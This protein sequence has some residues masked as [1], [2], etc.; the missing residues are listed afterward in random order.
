MK[1]YTIVFCFL[2]FGFVST[3]V[4]A[5]EYVPMLDNLNEWKFTTCN[6]GCIT[7]TYFTDGDTLVNGMNFKILDGYHYISRTFLLREVVAEKKV[8]L[9]IF[10][11][12]R[13]E[14]YLL[15]DFSLE[16][17]DTFE[18]FNPITPFPAEGGLFRLDSI[19]SRTSA[20]NNMYRHFYFSPTPGNTISTQNAVW[21]EGVGSLSILTAPG[22]DPDF[23]NVGHLSCSFKNGTRVYENLEE[24]AACSPS[25][26]NI[27]AVISPLEG[28]FIYVKEETVVV[29]NASEIEKVV[30]YSI[31]GKKVLEKQLNNNNG[32][33]VLQTGHIKKG[34]Y[35]LKATGRNGQVAT[36]KFVSG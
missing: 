23:D 18:M 9:K 34:L 17:G 7:D 26:L 3:Q 27:D 33:M 1:K 8:Y 6:S 10:L 24:I 21:I 32:H 28:V 35:I 16:E 25:I 4:Y 31:S 19:R 20:D 30:I 22:G 14:D 5:Q 11:P 12:N 29:E 36:F 15:Y 2:M 13:V